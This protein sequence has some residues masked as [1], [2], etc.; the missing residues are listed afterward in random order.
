MEG[1]ILSPEQRQFYEENGFL[2]MR[3]LVSLDK[4]EKYCDRFRKICKKE[5]EVG[6][7][8]KKAWKCSP[9]VGPIYH[10]NER[11]VHCKK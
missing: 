8:F 11:C 1:S 7:P 2:V 4:L 6:Y 9:Y 5:I 3:R 10:N